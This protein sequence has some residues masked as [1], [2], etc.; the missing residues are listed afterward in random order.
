LSYLE[1]QQLNGK[2]LLELGCGSGLLSVIAAKRGAHVTASDISSYAVVNT[3]HNALLNNVDI[4]VLRSDL[5]DA[6]QKKFDFV[7]INPPYY[8]GVPKNEVDLAWYCGENFEYFSKLFLQLKN[9]IQPD[10]DVIMVLTKGCDV[11]TIFEL[12]AKHQ[13]A[14]ELIEERNVLFDH[15]DYLFRI[16][17][18]SFAE[19]QV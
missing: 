16:I 19:V 15:K 3:Q 12:G 18:N 5:F 17:F 6:I 7:V 2:T 10:S 14:F 8:K 1:Q 11:N 13:F 4:D 9:H